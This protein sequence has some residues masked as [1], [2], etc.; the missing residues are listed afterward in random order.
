MSRATLSP[1][2]HGR[3]LKRK[4]AG[5]RGK[6]T[7][8]KREIAPRP[9]V[10]GLAGIVIESRHRMTPERQKELWQRLETELWKHG[11][12]VAFRDA[13]FR[14]R[15]FIPR[16]RHIGGKREVTLRL[17]YACLDDWRQ[18]EIDAAIAAVKESFKP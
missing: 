17:S 3:A 7:V 8:V 16:V 15:D 5:I 1:S 6:L 4:L 2:A 9:P 13:E 18:N 12:E 14:S 10:G 11:L